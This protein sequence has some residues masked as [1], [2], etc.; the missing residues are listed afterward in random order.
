MVSYVG[1]SLSESSSVPLGKY[2]VHVL[3]IRYVEGI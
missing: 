2:K 1:C 3:Y